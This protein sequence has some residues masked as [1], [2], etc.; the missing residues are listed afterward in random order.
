MD[1][2]LTKP[3]PFSRAVEAVAATLQIA[4]VRLRDHA[5]F[6]EEDERS[7]A[8]PAAQLLLSMLEDSSREVEGLVAMLEA[9]Q[10]G[11][12]PQ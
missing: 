5:N 3:M 6:A 9:R 8:L 7:G 2:D 4:L 10:Q 11:G 1:L 12:K